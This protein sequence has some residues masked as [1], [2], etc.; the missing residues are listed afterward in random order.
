VSY[1]LGSINAF[2]VT[3]HNFDQVTDMLDRLYTQFDD[4]ADDNCVFKLETIG[5]GEFELN[6]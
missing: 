2:H 4:L 6:D 3:C 5:D 1:I